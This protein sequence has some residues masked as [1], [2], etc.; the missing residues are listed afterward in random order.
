MKSRS[1]PLIAAL[2]ALLIAGIASAAQGQNAVRGVDGRAPEPGDDKVRSRAFNL[3]RVQQV[4][5][6]MNNL[7][8]NGVSNAEKDVNI[9]LKQN[10]GRIEVIDISHTQSTHNGIGVIVVR[11]V[12]WE[13]PPQ[14]G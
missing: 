2:L 9:W 4:H 5:L 8:S 10:A 6:V 3:N 7:D 11:I 1:L 13:Y 12:Y 14:K